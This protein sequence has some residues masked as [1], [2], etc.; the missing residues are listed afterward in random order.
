M[1]P[2]RISASPAS[3]RFRHVPVQATAGFRQ[4]NLR[5]LGSA[6]VGV[7]QNGA[8]RVLCNLQQPPAQP[9]LACTTTVFTECPSPVQNCAPGSLWFFGACLSGQWLFV[10]FFCQ[11]A[12]TSN[13]RSSSNRCRLPS[14]RRPLPSAAARNVLKVA[15]GDAGDFG[16]ELLPPPNVSNG[17]KTV[18][19]PPTARGDTE[20]CSASGGV[21]GSACRLGVLSAAGGAYW[22]TAIRCPSLGPSPSIGGGA[23]RPLTTLRP[24][25]PSLACLSLSTSADIRK[26]SANIRETSADIWETSVDIR[27]TSADIRGGPGNIHGH[28]RTSVF[29]FPFPW[30]V[31]PTDPPDFPC[32]TA[33]CRVHT[34]EGN[35]PRRWPGASKH[36]APPPSPHPGGG[37]GGGLTTPPPSDP[38]FKVGKK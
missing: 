11:Q 33:P 35:G 2:V 28:P 37:G 7:T 16:R 25:S 23:H 24:S 20:F 26:T 12:S 3:S 27:K 5:T 18:T 32:F 31:A 15:L 14:N 30:S 6:P 8:G 21:G 38:D 19:R 13:R 9:S 10:F 29:P 36:L 1:S 22:P 4:W 34:E 17:T